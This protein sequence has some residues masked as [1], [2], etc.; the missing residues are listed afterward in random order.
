LGSSK[1]QHGDGEKEAQLNDTKEPDRRGSKDDDLDRE[2]NELLQEIRVMLPG[3]QVLLAF[4]LTVAFTNRF[5]SLSDGER[6]VYYA[7]V[8]LTSLAIVLL[9]AP[10][11]QHRVR[12][13][14]H[15]KEALIV[16]SNRLFLLASVVVGAAIATVLFLLTEYLYGVGAASIAAAVLVG[17]MVVLWYVTP[18][19]RRRDRSGDDY[20][21]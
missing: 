16:S 2:L 12:F 21:G 3:V 10:G 14:E 19:R 13:R 20:E 7:A 4:L 5:A 1:A 15:D 11:V 9:M 17:I 8:G 6:G 18:V